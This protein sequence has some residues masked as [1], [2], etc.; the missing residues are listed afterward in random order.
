MYHNETIELFEIINSF[1]PEM[2]K[3]LP[4]YDVQHNG[5]SFSYISTYAESEHPIK[6]NEFTVKWVTERE[7]EVV[8]TISVGSSTLTSLTRT[9]NN[10]STDL[11]NTCT[12]LVSSDLSRLISVQWEMGLNSNMIYPQAMISSTIIKKTTSEMKLMNALYLRNESVLINGVLYD[13]NENAN[14]FTEDISDDKSHF[15]ILNVINLRN[16]FNELRLA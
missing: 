8:P 5:R 2:L 9:Y 7:D 15:S 6:Y 14:A 10:V 12:V 3:T 11:L 1:E 4:S 13:L 16:I